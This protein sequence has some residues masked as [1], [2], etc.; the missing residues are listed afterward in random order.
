ME[1]ITGTIIDV[2]EKKNKNGELFWKA[3]IDGKTFNFNKKPETDTNIEAKYTKNEWTDN[4]GNKNESRWVQDFKVVENV[5]QEMQNAQAP[6]QKATEIKD[7]AFDFQHI[8]KKCM[9]QA[10][11]ITQEMNEI[12]DNT[13]KW[14]GED[15]QKI[16]VSIFIA[17]TR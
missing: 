1:T 15:I 11:E 12:V 8:M 6:F 3:K 14:T 17:R 4:D 16:G 9:I 10:W 5:G 13:I 2:M 7:E